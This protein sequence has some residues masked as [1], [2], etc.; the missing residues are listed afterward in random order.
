[1]KTLPDCA[2]A[3]PYCLASELSD[4][5]SCRVFG[6]SLVRRSIVRP[7]RDRRRRSVHTRTPGRTERAY[8][9]TLL[10]SADD[11][12]QFDW[13]RTGSSARGFVERTAF[14][15][16]YP[17]VIQVGN[18]D[19]SMRFDIVDLKQSDV[20]LTA[21]IAVR[22]DSPSGEDRVITT[23]LH[24]VRLNGREVPTQIAVELDIGNHHETF[25]GG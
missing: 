21:V 6:E 25:T 24:R 19:P 3:G 10:T 22:N 18:V 23:L 14:D 8:Y 17:G 16:A 5:L 7:Q 2:T 1:M 4:S 9:A 11:T 20:N 13:E 12:T 15:E